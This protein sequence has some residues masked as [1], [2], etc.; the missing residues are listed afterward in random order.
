MDDLPIIIN[1]LRWLS[2]FE[3]DEQLRVTVP[4]I[5][6]VLREIEKL[7]EQQV[8]ERAIHKDYLD[9]M[10]PLLKNHREYRSTGEPK[11]SDRYEM[12]K[13]LRQLNV[14]NTKLTACLKRA[15]VM[16]NLSNAWSEYDFCPPELR[17]VECDPSSCEFCKKKYI[18]KGNT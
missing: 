6:E 17:N 15:Y 4:F 1:T 13:L 12:E 3:K 16:L 10:E 9:W 14:K 18:A 5:C 7:L 8:A 2:K 11:N